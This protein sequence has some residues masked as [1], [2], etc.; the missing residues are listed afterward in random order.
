MNQFNIFMWHDDVAPPN[1]D[2][3][4]WLRGPPSGPTT[5]T[6]AIHDKVNSILSTLDLDTTLD[7]VLPHSDMLC[8]IRYEE[9]ISSAPTPSYATVAT[10]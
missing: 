1:D 3:T 7:G 10:V 9:R 2:P 6:Q 4:P 8:V 5:R